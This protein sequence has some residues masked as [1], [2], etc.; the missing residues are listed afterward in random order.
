MSS[1][2]VRNESIMMLLAIA[3]KE[4]YRIISADIVGAYLNAKMKRDIYM[5]IN[6]FETNILCQL[7]NDYKKFVNKDDNCIYVKLI[8]ALYGCIESAKLFYELLRD[9]LFKYGFKIH[10]LDECIFL[11]ENNK[12]KIF[13]ATHVDDLLIAGNDES[14]LEK[15]KTFLNNEFNDIKYNEGEKHQYLGTNL[16]IKNESIEIDMIDSINKII[17]DYG[18][19]KQSTIPGTNDFFKNNESKLLD[20]QEKEI[21]HKYVAKLLY[22]SRLARIDILGYVSYLSTRVQIPTIEDKHK[23]E[24]LIGYLSYT[25]DKKLKL[26]NKISNQD[27]TITINTFIDSSHGLH[28]DFRG[29]TGIIVKLGECTIYARSSKQKI[30]TKSSAETELHGISEEIS[31]PLWMKQWLEYIGYKIKNIDL[32]VDNK[33]TIIMMLTGKAIGRNTRHISIRTFFIKQYLDDGTIKIVFTPTDELF[34]DLLTKSVQGKKLI[35][36]TDKLM[37]E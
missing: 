27:G 31:H 28:S 4:N 32:Y 3:L 33:S 1:S 29:R 22:V 23:L 10:P 7:N 2:T 25:I 11:Y 37:Y 34:A 5:K 16:N 15:F 26:S 17:I 35:K 30:N 13:I 18:N 21:F 9:T 6:R 36:F 14:E 24:K 8:K 20:K 12:N 19:I